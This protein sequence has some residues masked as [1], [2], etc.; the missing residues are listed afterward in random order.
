MT[1]GRVDR[2][3]IT[4]ALIECGGSI[5]F[6]PGD[7]SE[8]SA[9]Y[10]IENRNYLDEFANNNTRLKAKVEYQPIELL[11]GR[12]YDNTFMILDEAQNATKRQIMMLISRMG[13]GSKLMIIGDAEQSDI[14]DS[15]FKIILSNKHRVKNAAFVTLNDQDFFR[16]KNALQLYGEL[17]NI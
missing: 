5:G 15:F 14:N 1:S 8:K 12:N 7:I 11:R 2:I 10:F 9:P 16:N 13:V 3:L 17:C 6:L 4:R